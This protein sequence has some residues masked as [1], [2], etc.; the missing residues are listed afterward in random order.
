MTDN[1]SQQW[2]SRWLDAVASGEATMSQR[3]MTSIE[4]NGGIKAVVK[5]A[6]SKGVH[7]V[8][9]TDDKGKILVA[10]SREPFSTLC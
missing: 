2:I 5:A 8:K 1:K 9:L 4:A 10:A 6:R 3:A 7:L